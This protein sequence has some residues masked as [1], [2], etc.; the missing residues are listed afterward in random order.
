MK[1]ESP[2]EM[3]DERLESQVCPSTEMFRAVGLPERHRQ[4]NVIFSRT[5]RINLCIPIAGSH[6]NLTVA[7]F[8][9]HHEVSGHL[10]QQSG[11]FLKG[12]VGHRVVDK[13]LV[14]GEA[15][16]FVTV[17]MDD[18]PIRILPFWDSTTRSDVKIFIEKLTNVGR[19]PARS[20]DHSS[21]KHLVLE[22]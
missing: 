15:I 18:S 10:R 22:P 20:P 8:E 19:C 12:Y 2:A 3:I 17:I 11:P 16:K 1:I 4:V 7:V 6:R 5:Q 9:V 14:K 21:G 13:G